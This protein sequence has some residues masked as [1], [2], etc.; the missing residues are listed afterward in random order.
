MVRV[1]DSVPTEPNTPFITK[2]VRIVLSHLIAV[3]NTEEVL[4]KGTALVTFFTTE[5]INYIRIRRFTSGEAA[6]IVLAVT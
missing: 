3:F 1:K 6:D 4:D 5:G 2:E